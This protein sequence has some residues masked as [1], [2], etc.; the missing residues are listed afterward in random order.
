MA[1]GQDLCTAGSRGACL[2][3]VPFFGGGMVAGMGCA[4][5]VSPWEVTDSAWQ[6]G[7]GLDDPGV[8]LP[9]RTLCSTQP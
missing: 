7:E 8:A 9:G 5:C 3:E 4:E 1:Q 6:H 2:A